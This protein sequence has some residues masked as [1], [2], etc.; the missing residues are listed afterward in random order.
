M[1]PRKIRNAFVAGFC[2]TIAHSLL[3]LVHGKA[4][5]LPEFQPNEDIQRVVRWLVGAEV[6]P[7]VAWLLS[8]VN[9][10]LVWGFVFGQAYRFLPGKSAWLKGVSFAVFA[11]MI[12]GFLFFPLVGRGLFAS[13]LGLGATPAL[14]MLVALVVYSVTMSLVYHRLNEDSG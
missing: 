2:G 9:G 8:F 12:M 4:G 13:A 5:P 10:A 3:M 14:L 1:L 11:W 7:G 6:S